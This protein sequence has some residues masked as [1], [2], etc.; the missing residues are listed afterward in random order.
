MGD[1][2]YI[3]NLGNL[4]PYQDVQKV[5]RIFIVDIVEYYCGILHCKI[6]Q[7]YNVKTHNTL[8]NVYVD[9]LVFTRIACTS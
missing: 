3:K 8:V 2:I 1:I 9:L 6:K 5:R 4:F 7:F